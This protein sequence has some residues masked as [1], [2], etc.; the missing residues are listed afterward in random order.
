[1]FNLMRCAA[2]WGSLALATLFPLTAVSQ[3][4]NTPTSAAQGESVYPPWQHGANDDA[5]DRGLEF[6]VPDADNL[7]DFHGDPGSPLL[8]LYV[9]VTTSSP[10]L[11][12]YEPSRRATR[13]TRDIFTGR[14]FRPVCWC[15]R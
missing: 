2:A 9:G 4:A 1:M 13:N 5:T 15:G 11:P 12:S 14:P 8:V 7:A 6:T 10:W 3:T